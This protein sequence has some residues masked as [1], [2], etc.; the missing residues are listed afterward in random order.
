MYLDHI[1]KV[2]GAS[3]HDV[4]TRL[5]SEVTKL[6]NQHNPEDVGLAILFTACDVWLRGGMEKDSVVRNLRHFANK[7][8]NGTLPIIFEPNEIALRK[9]NERD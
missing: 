3:I 9:K 8:Q 5:R 7:M 6:C 1:S 4:R 2:R